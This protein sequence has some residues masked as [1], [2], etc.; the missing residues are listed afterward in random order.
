MGSNDLELDITCMTDCEYELQVYMER[1]YRL[2]LGEEVRVGFVR[3]NEEFWVRVEVKEQR[4]DEVRV[5]A[6]VDNPEEVNG[7]LGMYVNVGDSPQVPTKTDNSYKGE[8]IWNDGL[9]VFLN[10]SSIKPKQTIRMLL[11]G[12]SDM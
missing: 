4:F 11:T 2:G 9:G 1:E 10:S 5:M 8:P 6:F 7:A 12:S 3:Q